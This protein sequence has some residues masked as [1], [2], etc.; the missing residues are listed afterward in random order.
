M[1]TCFQDDAGLRVSRPGNP[2]PLWGVRMYYVYGTDKQGRPME[3]YDVTPY[4]TVADILAI[5]AELEGWQN[6]KIDILH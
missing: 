5:D 1:L 4:P 2:F 3:V 6:V